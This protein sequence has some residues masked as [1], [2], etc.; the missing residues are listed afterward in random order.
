MSVGYVLVDV[1]WLDP[2]ARESYV[3]EVGDSVAA[4]D[5]EFIARGP[6]CEALEDDWGIEGRLVMLRFPSKAR[7]LE[8]Y[9]SDTYAPLLELRKRGARTKVICFEGD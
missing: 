5:G 9:H 2:D 7:A 8:W 3:A 4:Y 1:T 6:E